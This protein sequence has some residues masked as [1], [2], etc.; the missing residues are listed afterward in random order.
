MSDAFTLPCYEHVLFVFESFTDVAFE[1]RLADRGEG[2]DGGNE[3]ARVAMML[4]IC[5]EALGLNELLRLKAKNESAPQTHSH[6][7]ARSATDLFK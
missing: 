2:M 1:N 4:Q 5:L 3:R 7:A 6:Y